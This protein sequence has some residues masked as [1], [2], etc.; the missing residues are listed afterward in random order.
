MAGSRYETLGKLQQTTGTVFSE[1]SYCLFLASQSI[2]ADPEGFV[3]SRLGVHTHVR[4]LPILL[5]WISAGYLSLF[6]L[7]HV[8]L[9]VCCPSRWENAG[10]SPLGLEVYDDS[11]CQI[12]LGFIDIGGWQLISSV[13]S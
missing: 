5:T 11:A 6:D 1:S 8:D 12:I 2:S 13:S 10:Y 4:R 9:D 7:W 3:S